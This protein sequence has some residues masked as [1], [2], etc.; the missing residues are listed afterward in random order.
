MTIVY[1][2]DIHP[3]PCYGNPLTKEVKRRAD[4]LNYLVLMESK[5]TR[6]HPFTFKDVAKTVAWY[7]KEPLV[8]AENAKK[9]LSEEGI[10]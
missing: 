8:V 6:E 4:V 9:M 1:Q 2:Y 7:Y 10:G 3:L 5:G